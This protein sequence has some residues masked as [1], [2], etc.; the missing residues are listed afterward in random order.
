MPPGTD[1]ETLTRYIT[2]LDRKALTRELNGYRGRLR[3]D[4]TPAFLCAQSEERL[5]HL[6]LGAVLTQRRLER[7]AAAAGSRG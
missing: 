7:G 2:R 3:L 6:L 4:F 5:Q 1:I